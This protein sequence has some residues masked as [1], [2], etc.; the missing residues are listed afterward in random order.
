MDLDP[1]FRYSIQNTI[2][3]YPKISIVTPSYNQGQFLEATI[4]SVLGQAYPNLEYIIMDGGSTDDSAQI[5]EKYADK[6]YY[7]HSK[8]DNGQAAAINEGF[9]MASGDI[10]IWLNSD[11]LLM[12]NVLTYIA[13][14]A[15]NDPGKI[16]IGN[17]IHF[18]ETK[19][20][21]LKSWGS[22]VAEKHKE[23]RL[24]LNDYIIQPSSF[25]SME[26]WK[27][28]GP[29]DEVMYF[30]FD[31]EWFLRA[32]SKGIEFKAVDKC[33][34]MYRIHEAHKTGNGGKRKLGEVGVIYQ[35]YSPETSAL[36]DKLLKMRQEVFSKFF[37]KIYKWIGRKHQYGFFFKLFY[38]R[39]FRKHSYKEINMILGMI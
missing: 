27:Q 8:K 15:S 22:K 26:T 2:M 24:D 25:W 16:F 13:E 12:P 19:T 14:L 4:L 38:P 36:Y 31:W 11:D 1:L 18:H 29:L 6:L 21:E 34:S 10:L 23:V 28:V 39:M 5:I 37:E 35:R 30:A 20:G 7:W 9:G 32:K 33:L 17:C 3:H